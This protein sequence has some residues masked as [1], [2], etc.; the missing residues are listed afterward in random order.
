MK[1]TSLGI[2]WTVEKDGALTNAAI[3]H[4]LCVCMEILD[5]HKCCNNV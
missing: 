1:L 5:I 2:E 3:F 4:I